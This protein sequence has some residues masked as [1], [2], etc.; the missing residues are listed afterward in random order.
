MPWFS[1]RKRDTMEM[2]ETTPV[3][4]SLPMETP[5][6]TPPKRDFRAEG[7]RRDALIVGLVKRQS[8]ITSDLVQLAVSRE[9]FDLPGE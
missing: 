9:H 4:I 3:S 1:R 8:V 2:Q 5:I 7:Q 6:Q